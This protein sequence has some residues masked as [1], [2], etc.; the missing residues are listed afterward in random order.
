MKKK[1]SLIL[2]TIAFIILNVLFFLWTPSD[3]RTTV[4]WLSYGFSLFVYV[5]MCGGIIYNSGLGDEPYHMIVTSLLTQYFGLQLLTAI[6]AI[7]LGCWFSKLSFVTT[8]L[9]IIFLT[10][11]LLGVIFYAVRIYTQITANRSTAKSLQM[12]QV[13]HEYVHNN[14]VQIESLVSLTDD[15]NA[16]KELMCL[17]DIV[18]NSPNQ[19]SPTG[20]TYEQTIESQMQVLSQMVAARNWENVVKIART[21]QA[22]ANMRNKI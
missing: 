21:L 18:H 7:A 14:S 6:V 12:Q 2:M 19:V 3:S 5:A 13:Q 16:K 11:Y 22:T 17:Y 10:L 15:D 1:I 8:L 20:H 4:V 9:T